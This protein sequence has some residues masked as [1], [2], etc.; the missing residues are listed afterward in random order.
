MFY[1]TFYKWFQAA[2][3]Y[4]RRAVMST[5]TE[6]DHSSFIQKLKFTCWVQEAG[7]PRRAEQSETS[8]EV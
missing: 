2:Q 6:N 4:K 8:P 7:P 1:V 5:G 3:I